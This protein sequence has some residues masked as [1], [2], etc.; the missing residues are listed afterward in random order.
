[1][2]RIEKGCTVFLTSAYILSRLYETW[3]YRVLTMG[4][5]RLE[6]LKT[7]EAIETTVTECL[8]TLLNLGSHIAKQPKVTYFSYS[9]VTPAKQSKVIYILCSIF[10][11]RSLVV[12]CSLIFNSVCLAS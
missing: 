4:V 5:A 10:S 7:Q 6:E 1:M 2:Y 9:F 12:L 8:V 11:L 3:C